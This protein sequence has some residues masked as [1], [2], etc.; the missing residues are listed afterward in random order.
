MVEIHF[1]SVVI[2]ILTLSKSNLLC[3]IAKHILSTDLKI[4]RANVAD[5]V[6]INKK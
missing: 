1:L 6:I 2:S 5:I 4:I 3:V